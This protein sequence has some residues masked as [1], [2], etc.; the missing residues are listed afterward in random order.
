MIR[1]AVAACEQLGR[2]GNLYEVGVLLCDK[3]HP[4]PRAGY[5]CNLC[6][7]ESG[8]EAPHEMPAQGGREGKADGGRGRPVC[9]RV[10]VAVSFLG[11]REELG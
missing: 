2:F 7:V 9:W 6:L 8:A 5:V 10:T 3:R 4:Y 11:W 1:R